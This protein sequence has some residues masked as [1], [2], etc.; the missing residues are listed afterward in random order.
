MPN[1]RWASPSS[2]GPLR[3]MFMQAVFEAGGVAVLMEALARHKTSAG[4]CHWASEALGNIAIGSGARALA[5][6][7]ALPLLLEALSLHKTH[8]KVG[9]H[10]S[11]PLEMMAK[12]G[13]AS[14]AAS[15][16]SAGAVPLLAAVWHARVAS[17][18][19]CGKTYQTTDS[20]LA[21]AAKRKSKTAKAWWKSVC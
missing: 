14:C 20:D 1:Q 3:S 2:E 13:G 21:T 7:E 12:Y 6:L 5:V 16:V 11:Y 17:F 15:I 9:E 18:L 4:V 10:V 8:A 19:T